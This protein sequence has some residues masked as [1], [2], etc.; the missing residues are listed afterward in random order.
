MSRSETRRLKCAECPFTI[1]L[2]FDN[3]TTW[4][5]NPKRYLDAIGGKE[6]AYTETEWRCQRCGGRA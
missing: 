2:S 1:T 5:D 4:S 6:G 3:A